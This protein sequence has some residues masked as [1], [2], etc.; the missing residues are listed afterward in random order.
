MVAVAKVTARRL[1]NRIVTLTSSRTPFQSEFYAYVFGRTG[2]EIVAYLKKH[3]NRK[4]QP[5]QV[6]E[7]L[8]SVSCLCY[9]VHHRM[10]TKPKA[11]S[12]NPALLW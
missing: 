8:K 2:N 4:N 12:I 1:R 11:M 3:Q 7:I 6:A 9:K 10:M 5:Q